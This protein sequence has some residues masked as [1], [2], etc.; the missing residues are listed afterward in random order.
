MIDWESTTTRP[1]WACAHLPVLLQSSPFTA[2]LFREAVAKLAEGA[3]ASSSSSSSS[4]GALAAEWLR[5]EALGAPLR[6]AHRCVEWDGWEE[7]LV[8]S[9]LGAEEHEDTWARDALA[10]AAAAAAAAAAAVGIESAGATVMATAAA[11]VTASRGGGFESEGEG[12]DGEGPVHHGQHGHGHGHGNGHGKA[13]AHGAHGKG[14]RAGVDDVLRPHGVER[15]RRLPLRG[16]APATAEEKE[17]EKALAATGDF[18]G[19]RGGEL[20]RRLEALLTVNGNGDGSVRRGDVKWE[21][22]GGEEREYEAGRE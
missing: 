1:L 15:R 18:C 21:G 20:G 2:R 19:G 13:R 10:D 8:A 14:A 7:G 11:T 3:P 5:W 12:S 16:L 9:I 22:G 17:R 6:L 4:L